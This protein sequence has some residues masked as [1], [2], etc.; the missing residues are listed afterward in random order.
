MQPRFFVF[1]CTTTIVCTISCRYH[2]LMLFV[3]GR[4][5]GGGRGGG[6]RIVSSHDKYVD[7]DL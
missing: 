2:L 5:W 6:L 1:A 4:I 3:G 7:A